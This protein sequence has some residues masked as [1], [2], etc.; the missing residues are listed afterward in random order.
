VGD[1]ITPSVSQDLRHLGMKFKRLTPVFGVVE[2]S[3]ALSGRLHVETG[4]EK[5]SAA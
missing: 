1:K 3:M 5:F 2:N 4:S